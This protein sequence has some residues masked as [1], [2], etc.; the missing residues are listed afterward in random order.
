MD[1]LPTLVG[2]Q[3]EPVPIHP[4]TLVRGTIGEV[5]EML[6]GQLRPEDAQDKDWG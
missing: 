1:I 4:L 5:A 6:D 2:L 3:G